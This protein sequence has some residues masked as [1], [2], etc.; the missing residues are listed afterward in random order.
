MAPDI[1]KGI[2]ISPA[3]VPPLDPDFRA[4]SLINREFRRAVNA[5]GNA[6]PCRIAVEQGDGSVSVYETV[7]FPEGSEMFDYN[8]PYIERIVKFLLWQRGGW[9]VFIGGPAAIGDYVRSVY[10]PGG[11]RKFDYD[12]MSRVY[13]RPFTVVTCRPEDVPAESQKSVP[14][15]RHLD[16][17]RVGFDLGASDRKCAAV[18]DGKVIFADEVVW[19]PRNQSDPNYHYEGVLHSIK[20]AASHLPRVDAIGGSAAGVYVNNRVR[21]GSLYRGVSEKDFEDKIANMFVRIGNELGVP[22]DVVNDGEVTALAGAMSLEDNRIL[23]VAMGSSVA[24]G[25]VNAEGNIT[26]WLNELAF[27]PVDYRPNGP[28][29]EWSGD[30]GCAVQYFCQQGTARLATQSGL[31]L[32]NVDLPTRLVNL[33]KKMKDGDP[34]A[35][36]LYETVG[37]E[38]GY[39]V[40][41]YAEFYDIK[42]LM[43]LGRVT[44]GEGGDIIVA[45]AQEVLDTEFPELKGIKLA[46]PDEKARRVGQ[47]IAAASLPA[48][49]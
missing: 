5:T 42:H 1:C 8:L 26:T 10:S 23:G 33:Q 19:D 43:V 20:L 29:D 44:T 13:E 45:K 28:E 6:T 30:R 15:G 18:M 46:M 16:G 17:C 35:R 36:K 41:H 27:C 21:V 24:A 49:K 14:L 2:T 3:F 7:V 40:A 22:L 9:K 47:S 39:A 4:A 11:E 31:D 32:G 37:I 12:F 25:Y 38:F 48:I 34:T